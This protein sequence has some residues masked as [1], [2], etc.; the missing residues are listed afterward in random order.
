[1]T[2]SDT[3]IGIARGLA[4]AYGKGIAH[5]DLKPANIFLLADGQVKMLDFGLAREIVSQTAE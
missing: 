3:A 5:R 2:R 4:A 1:M